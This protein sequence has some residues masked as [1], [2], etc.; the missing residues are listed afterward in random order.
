MNTNSILY[1]LKVWLTS[2]G[3]APAMFIIVD[4]FTGEN[5]YQVSWILCPRK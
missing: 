4:S 3:V 2:V 5:N 1:S